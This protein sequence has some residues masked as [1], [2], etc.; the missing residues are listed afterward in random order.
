MDVAVKNDRSVLCGNL[1]DDSLHY[2]LTIDRILDLA[3]RVLR[4]GRW[5]KR[6]GV[7]HA[8]YAGKPLDVG[9]CNVALARRPRLSREGDPASFDL[10]L[11]RIA[12]KTGVSGQQPRRAVGE[13]A[14]ARLLLARQSDR[15]LFRDTFYALD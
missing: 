5:P 3:L 15:N 6:Y 9:E 14:I 11:D 1:D 7:R 10:D 13:L 12:M 8:D 4:S 2:R